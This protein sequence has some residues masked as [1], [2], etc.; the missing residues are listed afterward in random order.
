MFYIFR[1]S[2]RKGYESW[3][4]L[5]ILGVKN[6]G[7][8]QIATKIMLTE[9]DWE[10]YNSGHFIPSNIMPSL[11]IKYGAFDLILNQLKSILAS[12][13]DSKRIP[14]I[15]QGAL[16]TIETYRTS[17]K[18]SITVPNDKTI[19]YTDFAE[20][21]IKCMK[22]GTVLKTGT[23]KKYAEGSIR[24]YKEHLSLF[25]R[26]ESLSSKRY[27]LDEI[28]KDF[29]SEYIS[30]RNSNNGS[31]NSVKH[32]LCI[33]RLTIKR[34]YSLGLTKNIDF[35]RRDF[36]VCGRKS[37]SI[38]LSPERI[39]EFEKFSI[40]SLE[41]F[42]SMINSSDIEEYYRSNNGLPYKSHQLWYENLMKSK[43]LFLLGYYTGQRFSDYSRI[44]KSMI[45]KYKG[46]KF[47]KLIQVKE[48]KK[49]MIP[50][51]KRVMAILRRNNGKAPQVGYAQFCKLI[52]HIGYLLGWTWPVDFE[53]EEYRREKSDKFCDFICT[54]TARRSFATNAYTAGVPIRSIMAITGHTYEID[55]RL[56]IKLQAEEYGLMASKAFKDT[57]NK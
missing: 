6:L 24:R 56:Y 35:R 10:V 20:Y 53:L 1:A 48:D 43:D 7:S 9:E 14:S 22:D 2:K 28:T 39:K 45:V 4:H 55:F 26:F 25:F 19:F 8:T 15:I 38:Y 23:T 5:S 47:I 29:V 16:K 3:G 37:E 21:I 51:D 57:I 36:R 30:W 33:I 54:H 44:D 18:S 50:L 31:P 27:T 41:E 11:G 32:E 12:E 34:A 49:V 13:E 40:S 17:K 46:R 42:E 52:K